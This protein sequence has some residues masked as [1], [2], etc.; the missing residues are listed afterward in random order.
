[1]LA[2]I[3]IIILSIGNY[4]EHF[5]ALRTEHAEAFIFFSFALVFCFAILLFLS[6]IYIRRNVRLAR[7]RKSKDYQFKYQLLIYEAIIESQEAEAPESVSAAAD[8]FRNYGLKS[9]LRKQALIDMMINLKKSFSGEFERQLD[10]VYR[11]LALYDVSL[12]KIRN[13]TW[14]KKAQGIREIAAMNY[15]EAWLE[16]A[17]LRHS[18]NKILAQEAQ[19]AS[20]RLA[21][22]K[23]LYFL[24]NYTKPISL[25]QQINFYHY[26]LKTD[27]SL[28]PDFQRWLSS[29]NESVVIFSLKMIRV[30]NQAEAAPV[31]A[32]L[33]KHSSFQVKLQAIQTLTKLQAETYANRLFQM[34][35]IQDTNIRVATIHALGKLGNEYHKKLLKS[36]LLDDTYQVR[37]AAAKALRGV[38]IKYDL[39][40]P[41]SM[42][43]QKEIL[44][45]AADPML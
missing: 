29:D 4:F 1:M 17:K 10:Q 41:H 16:I 5:V 15:Q 44:N 27:K 6:V 45:H 18:R 43:R 26:L 23:P 22:G 37:L 20:I 30:F 36:F 14:S 8:K 32:D 7:N 28:L 34:L 21:E 39:L 11:E 35:D 13:G 38:Q 9:Q 33:L 3:Y 31:V 19:M 12:K 24:D 25:W 42:A 40:D 2:Y